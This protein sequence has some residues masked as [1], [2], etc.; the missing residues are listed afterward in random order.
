MKPIIQQA[1]GLAQTISGWWLS[2]PSEKY[3]KVTWE[4]LG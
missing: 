4:Y 1:L 3:I 2:H